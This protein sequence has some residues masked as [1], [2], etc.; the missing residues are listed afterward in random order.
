MTYQHR[1]LK[2]KDLRACLVDLDGL[3]MGGFLAV[4]P[5]LDLLS[6]L[7]NP[8][9]PYAQARGRLNF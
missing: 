3:R 9:A 8:R 6:T 2:T 5:W 4:G 1:L 7:G